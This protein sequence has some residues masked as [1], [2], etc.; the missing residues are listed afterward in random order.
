[1]SVRS[2][3]F[4][5]RAF[6]MPRATTAVQ[7]YVAPQYRSALPPWAGANLRKV[8]G[9]SNLGDYKRFLNKNR[10]A[11]QENYSGDVDWKLFRQHK[12]RQ[13]LQGRHKQYI[14]AR[15]ADNA[16]DAWTENFI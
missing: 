9:Q 14:A 2:E 1:M 11:I 16:H 10:S 13:Y 8:H 4:Q 12:L 6:A 15:S 3:Y 7:P 5:K